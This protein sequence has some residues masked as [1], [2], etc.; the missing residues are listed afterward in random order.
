MW[1]G[2]TTK[3][4]PKRH[5]YSDPTWSYAGLGGFKIGLFTASIVPLLA[6]AEENLALFLNIKGVCATMCLF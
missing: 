4:K 6:Q 5:P 1:V 2:D 3:N